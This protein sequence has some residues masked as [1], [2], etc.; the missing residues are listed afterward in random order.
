MKSIRATMKTE[1][2]VISSCLDVLEAASKVSA[3]AVADLASVKS[4]LRRLSMLNITAGGDASV[5][6]EPRNRQRL[7][8]YGNGGEGWDGDRWEENYAGPL[9]VKVQKAMDDEFGKGAVSVEIGEKGHVEVELLKTT[10]AAAPAPKA[11]EQAPMP[12]QAFVAIVPP[13][14]AHL[15][16]AFVKMQ[17]IADKYRAHFGPTIGGQYPSRGDL[18]PFRNQNDVTGGSH[19][20]HR[21]MSV[22]INIGGLFGYPKDYSV[23]MRRDP[24]AARSATVLSQTVKNIVKKEVTKVMQALV[25]KHGGF[26]QSFDGSSYG[27]IGWVAPAYVRKAP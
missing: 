2:G 9:R 6:A 16:A 10:P 26:V 11:A 1:L 22:G 8:H 25:A 3:A 20:A 5:S 27:G 13:T 12:E 4:V 15:A 17:K 21:L 24:A 7:D 18:Q 19:G 23:A 14:A